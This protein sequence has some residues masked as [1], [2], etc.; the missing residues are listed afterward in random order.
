METYQDRLGPVVYAVARTEGFY[1]AGTIAQVGHNPGALF[2]HGRYL[3]FASDAD[4]WRELRAWFP[5][6]CGPLRRALT[7]YNP[8]PGYADYV[9]RLGHLDPKMEVC[10]DHP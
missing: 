3:A 10:D 5:R 8:R 6:H 2:V 7:V 1:V 4:G 9:I